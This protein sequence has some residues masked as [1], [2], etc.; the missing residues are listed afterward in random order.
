MIRCIPLAAVALLAACAQA[1]TVACGPDVD[2]MA[3]RQCAGL[4][5]GLSQFAIEKDA[6]PSL[7]D[8][9]SMRAATLAEASRSCAAADARAGG[10]LLARQAD[11][12]LVAHDRALAAERSRTL[13]ALRQSYGEID[14][15][16]VPPAAFSPPAT[17]ACAAFTV[18]AP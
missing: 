1:P 6:A 7:A 15:G 14:R 5:A 3:L 17:E 13:Q 10:A 2:R 4:Y 8:A 18:S 12:Q 11:P 9:L 16:R